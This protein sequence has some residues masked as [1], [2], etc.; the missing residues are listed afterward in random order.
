MF[1]TIITNLYVYVSFCTSRRSNQRFSQL[2][3][4]PYANLDEIQDAADKMSLRVAVYDV[5]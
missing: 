2:D 5:T 4:E 3:I 1:L